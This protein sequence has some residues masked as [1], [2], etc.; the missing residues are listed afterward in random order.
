M[1]IFFPALKKFFQALKKFFQALAKNFHAL[2]NFLE[3]ISVR[4]R[5]LAVG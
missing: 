5:A 4:G 1:K 3:I 2:E